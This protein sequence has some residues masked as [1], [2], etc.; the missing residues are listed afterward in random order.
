MHTLYTFSLRCYYLALLIAS[1][2]NARAKAWIDGRRGWK[3]DLRDKI[4]KIHETESVETGNKSSGTSHKSPTPN[5]QSPV[6]N[7]PPPNPHP[8]TPTPQPPTILVPFASPGGGGAG[9]PDN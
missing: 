9:R 4:R 5:P 6:R 2:F 7:P 8:P 1:L 3:A